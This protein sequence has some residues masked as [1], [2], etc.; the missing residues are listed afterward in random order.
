MKKILFIDRDGTLVIEPPIDLQLDSL[1]K[2]E[3]Y[4][5]VFQYLARIADELEYE[6]VMVS[7]QDGLG[8]SLFPEN[9]FWPAQNKI[10]QAFENEGIQFA[11]ILIDRSF[12]EDQAPTRKPGTAM[13]T[14]YQKG[15]YDLANSCVIGDRATDVQLA[16]NMGCKSIF[17][18]AEANADAD[19]ITQNW[20]E[21]YQW[22]KQK[23]RTARV[24]RQT[25]ETR[26]EIEL[27]L[28]GTGKGSMNT[29]LAFFDHM[30]DQ[31]ARHGNFDLNIKVEGD[32]KVDEHHSIEDVAITLGETFDIALGLKKGIERYGFLLPMDDS[33]AQVA[34]DFGGRSWLVW[35][36]DFKREKIGDVPTEMFEHFF[37]S[38]CQNAKCNLNIKVEGTNEHHKIESIFKAFA[39]TLK[40]ACSKTNN[41][42]IPSTKGS[43]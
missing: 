37:R 8:T 36:A 7:N 10:I 23:P 9:T 39:K 15:N 20:A 41:F 2:L 17:L 14:H 38:F 21:I 27:N 3:F 1:E 29:S 43:L 18:S 6:L 4:P 32:L 22:L 13:L 11:E 33:L 42:Q 40:M 5:G 26:V 16:K 31:L 28:D 24:I 30:L 12:P 25:M 19:L 34:L 35:N